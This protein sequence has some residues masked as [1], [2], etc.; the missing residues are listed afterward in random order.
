MFVID[1][2]N[3]NSGALT[4]AATVV[5]AAS[6]V[7]TA[8][9]TRSL[10]KE[11]RLLREAG[12]EPRVVAYLK[13]DPHQANLVKFVLANVGQGPARDV[14]FTFQADEDDFEN[15][16]VFMRN[17][18]D[19]TLTTMLPQGERIETFF[20]IGT[21]L[22]EEPKL[23]PFT[24]SVKCHDLSGKGHSAEYKLNVAQFTGF[25]TGSTP[26]YQSVRALERIETGIG[27]LVRAIQIKQ[28]INKEDDASQTG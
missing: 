18:S 22:M 23:E 5:I 27:R 12:M 2:L 25:V 24:V 9:L 16:D 7:V 21:K 4:A 19:R 15:H 1:W 8:L 13:L 17:S 6:A 28:M 10:A 26:E 20:G 11:N 3:A 14:E